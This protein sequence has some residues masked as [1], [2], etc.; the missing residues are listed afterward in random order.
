ML[1]RSFPSHD[2]QAIVDNRPYDSFKSFVEANKGLISQKKMVQFIKSGLF[3]SF[4][5]D[6]RQNMIAFVKYAIPKKEKLT[7][8]ALNKIGDYVPEKYRRYVKL[9][10]VKKALKNGLK[11]NGVLGEFF[12]NNVPFDYNLEEDKIV[13]DQKEFNKWFNKEMT[14]LKEWLKTE[15]A[16][17]VEVRVRRNAFWKENCAGTAE[18]W[19][20]E[21]LNYY[22]FEHFL[23]KTNLDTMFDCKSFN[24]LPAI[25]QVKVLVG[26]NHKF[27]I[28][29][30]NIICGTVISKNNVKKTATILTTSGVAICRLGDELFSK[31][32]QTI[33]NDDMK[34]ESWLTRGANLVL[35]GTRV[36]N[37][38][39]VKK[40]KDA[41]NVL[42]IVNQGYRVTLQKR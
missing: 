3:R 31:Y 7:T 19:Y 21:T 24:D 34:D 1:F 15:E 39:R 14:P 35:L 11:I 26:K 16:L 36:G 33:K 9:Y 12:I 18:S 8:T 22:P 13:V 32:N 17:D 37:E 27:P 2:I 25:P 41:T 38:F 29:Q 28:Y 10:Q 4:C 30:T 42:K 40:V 5:K 6:T 23:T 20:F